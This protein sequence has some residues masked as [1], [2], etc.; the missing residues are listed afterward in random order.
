MNSTM[1]GVTE[2]LSDM[3]EKFGG[4]FGIGRKDG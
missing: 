4:W 2:T 1:G 3:K